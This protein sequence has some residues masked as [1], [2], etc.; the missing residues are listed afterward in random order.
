MNE[1]KIDVDSLVYNR[2]VDDI[3]AEPHKITFEF[4]TGPNLDEFKLICMRMG[5]ALGYDW[6]SL[7]KVFGG[8]PNDYILDEIKQEVLYNK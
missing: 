3:N 4:N 6:D 8:I 7:V 5:S 1:E 2:Y